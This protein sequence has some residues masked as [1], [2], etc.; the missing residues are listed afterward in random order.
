M[1]PTFTPSHGLG[2]HSG[3]GGA[4]IPQLRFPAGE[5]LHPWVHSGV[6]GACI[7]QLRFPA[8]ERCIRDLAASA[9]VCRDGARQ[10][11]SAAAGRAWGEA[12][13][14]WTL[15]REREGNR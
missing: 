15:R 13:L 6:G 1:W 11:F 14:F 10:A 5:E 12:L 9:E 3:F 8:E 7:P 4:C 2:L